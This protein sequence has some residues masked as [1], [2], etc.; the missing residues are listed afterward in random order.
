MACSTYSIKRWENENKIPEKNNLDKVMKL[1]PD[2]TQDIKEVLE[3]AKE[4]EINNLPENTL[5][6]KI[7]KVRL[8]NNL[9]RENF[10]ALLGYSKYSIKHWEFGTRVPAKKALKKVENIFGI[11]LE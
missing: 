4:K 5:G 10:G 9:S 2:N 8:Q 3:K 6:Q 1:F 7:R 11:K